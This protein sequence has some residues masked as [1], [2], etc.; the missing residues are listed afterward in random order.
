[1]IAAEAFSETDEVNR[2]RTGSELA[3]MAALSPAPMHLDRDTL[4]ANGIFG[5]E[6][7]DIR[8]RTFVLLRSQLM[9]R[10]YRSGGRIL[11]ITSTQAGDGKTYIA[12]N[13]AA[14]LSRIH[15]TV[16]IDLDLRHPTL[17]ARFGLDPPLGIDD[18]LAGDA[19]L[20][21]AGTHVAAVDLTL[22]GVRQ[23]RLASATF[24]AVQRLGQM[25]DVIRNQ[26]R[27]PICIVDTPP[28]LVVDDILL[29]AE[30]VDGVLMV[31][32]EGSTTADDVA[33]AL[34]ILAPTPVVG[35]VL[36]KSLTSGKPPTD[37]GDYYLIS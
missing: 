23:P 20:E 1:M 6:H 8:A 14:A 26:P 7:L 36:N 29:I 35:S 34:R 11:A 17:A 27:A 18:Y 9:N 33:N 32:E 5:F 21:D 28:I 10:F 3:R 13:V 30:S 37:Y 22:Y 19:L 25:F 24:L 15:P 4:I 12:A 31:I 2:L 16:L